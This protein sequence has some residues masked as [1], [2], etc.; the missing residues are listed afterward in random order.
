MVGVIMINSLILALYDYSDRDNNGTYNQILDKL[1]LGCSIIFIGEASIKIIA[2]GL[3]WHK[4]AYLRIGWNLIDA[5]VVIS[6]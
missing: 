3:I 2:K 1:N 4:E 5:L 6:G